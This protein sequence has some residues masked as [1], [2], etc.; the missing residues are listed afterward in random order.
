MNYY[1][2]YNTGAGDFWFDGDLDE[3]MRKADEGIAYTQ[4][5]VTIY[6]AWDVPVAIR[7]W[8]NEPYKFADYE[9]GDFG[10]YSEWINLLEDRHYNYICHSWTGRL[11]HLS[12]VTYYGNVFVL[13]DRKGN[14]YI[15]LPDGTDRVMESDLIL[16][17]PEYTAEYYYFA[18]IFTVVDE[19]VKALADSIIEEQG[20]VGLE[21][22]LSRLTF[23]DRLWDVPLFMGAACE[24]AFADAQ[25]EVESLIEDLYGVKV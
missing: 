14:F 25:A 9:F 16:D 4:K 6:R 2:D 15:D 19:E 18:S 21:K 8:Y 13:I 17:D 5:D 1:I 23:Y 12:E 3:A 22:T 24:K 11:L 7:L 10:H 20:E